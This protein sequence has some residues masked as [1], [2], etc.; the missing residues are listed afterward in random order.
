MGTC[1]HPC[2]GHCREKQCPLFAEDE[3]WPEVSSQV[4]RHEFASIVARIAR[5]L[6]LSKRDYAM[7]VHLRVLKPFPNYSSLP[8][9]SAAPGHPYN[10]PLFVA[11]GKLYP[12]VD[13]TKPMARIRCDYCAGLID[14]DMPQV[15]T[16]LKNRYH[17]LCFQ[18]VLNPEDVRRRLPLKSS[19][20]P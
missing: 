11:S 16:H 3:T 8:K 20:K 17:D 12:K 7:R 14:P 18:Y 1:Q 6:R 13:S 19:F 5:T 9:A 2:L 15:L 10:L 4:P